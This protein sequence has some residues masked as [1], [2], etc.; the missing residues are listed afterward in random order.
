MFRAFTL[1]AGLATALLLSSQN[2][3]WAQGFPVKPVR[4]VVPYTAAGPVDT[5]ARILSQKL[6]EKWQ[7]Q[8][9]V[10]NRAGSG[11]AIGANAVAKAPP[12]GYMLLIG[13]AGPMTVYPYLRKSLLYSPERDFE[14]VALLVTSCMVLIAHPSLPA[15]SV[16]DLVRLAKKAPGTLTYSSSGVG[17]LQHLGMSLLESFA[18]ISMVHVPYKGAAPALMDVISGQIHVQFNNV[19]G[20]LQQVN[21]GR[22]RALAVSSAQ[23]SSALPNVPPVAAVYPDFDIGAWM[24]LYAPAAIPRELLAVLTRDVNAAMTLPDTKQRIAELGADIIAAGPAELA[25]YTR[26]ESALFGKAV[27]AAKIEKE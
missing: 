8:V 22:V 20:V 26:R 3:A 25:A 15:K 14:P 9:I 6:S 24:G 18:G 2:S 12:D 10:D 23:R 7:H 27:A 11:G 4:L 5:V 21:S 17:A 16:T 1:T 19:V 13:N